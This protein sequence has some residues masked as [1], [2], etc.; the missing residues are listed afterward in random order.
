[1]PASTLALYTDPDLMQEQAQE[2]ADEFIYF[3]FALMYGY[4]FKD[5][6]VF[7]AKASWISPDTETEDGNNETRVD[8]D[9]LFNAGLTFRF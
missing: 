1:L 3:G 2:G 9:F 6:L 7:D 4:R 5:W 8:V